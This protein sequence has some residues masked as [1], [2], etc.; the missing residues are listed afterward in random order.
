MDA[1]RA[2][3]RACVSLLF[4]CA[5]GGGAQQQGGAGPGETVPGGYDDDDRVAPLFT[6]ILLPGGRR[7]GVSGSVSAR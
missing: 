1:R 6:W 3:V 2:C 5:F 7:V 4:C